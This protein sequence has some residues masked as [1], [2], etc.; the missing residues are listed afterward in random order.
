MTIVDDTTCSSKEPESSFHSFTLDNPGVHHAPFRFSL[1][2]SD[3]RFCIACAH[4]RVSC[5]RLRTLYLV[6]FCRHRSHSYDTHDYMLNPLFFITI[7]IL[8]L[9]FSSRLNATINGDG[10]TSARVVRAEIESTEDPDNV[11]NLL[12]CIN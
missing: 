5:L 10:C 8:M 1:S 6:L 7:V 11:S 3:P 12:S 9:V 4:A 2:T